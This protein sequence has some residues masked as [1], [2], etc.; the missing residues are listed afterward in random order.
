MQARNRSLSVMGSGAYVSR[1]V[2]HARMLAFCGGVRGP[3]RSGR[4]VHLPEQL[5]DV[6]RE[7]YRKCP[8]Q[9]FPR[10]GHDSLEYGFEVVR[11]QQ[12]VYCLAEPTTYP[13]LP[14][15][16]SLHSFVDQS[17]WASLHSRKVASPS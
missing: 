2:R 15:A 12:L 4:S 14:A 7:E 17:Y 10:E 3:R 11:L 13:P 9:D 6:C 1:G 8:C 16:R 5:P